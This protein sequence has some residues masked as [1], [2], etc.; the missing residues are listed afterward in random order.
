MYDDL[1]PTHETPAYPDYITTPTSPEETRELL[2][3]MIESM[4]DEAAD[5]LCRF[6]AWASWPGPGPR[7]G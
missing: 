6:L 3:A 5:A 2:H 7:E 1:F 4:T